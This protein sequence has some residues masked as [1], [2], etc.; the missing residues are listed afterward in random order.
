MSQFSVLN[1][2]EPSGSKWTEDDEEYFYK[3]S[4][5]LEELAKEYKT[6]VEVIRIRKGII[7]LRMLEYYTI[8]EISKH[9]QM[10]P[11]EIKLFI[12]IEKHTQEPQYAIIKEINTKINH[13]HT[14]IDNRFNDLEKQ[15]ADRFND[16]EDKYSDSM[17]KL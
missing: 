7:A 17:N 16:L 8:E 14:E 12:E 13:I 11:E 4:K 15:I 9:L 6:N 2:K 10:T 3:T 1:L 5:S